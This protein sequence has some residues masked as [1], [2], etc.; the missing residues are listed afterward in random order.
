M[1]DKSFTS[2]PNKLQVKH[3]TYDYNKNRHTTTAG[4]SRPTTTKPCQPPVTLADHIAIANEPWLYTQ[5]EVDAAWE[6]LNTH[7]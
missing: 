4:H 2:W 5:T 1:S 6:Y 3:L 7:P